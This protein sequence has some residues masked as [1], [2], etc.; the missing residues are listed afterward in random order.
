M[1]HSVSVGRGENHTSLGIGGYFRNGS[2]PAVGDRLNPQGGVTF[3]DR[4]A[5][6]SANGRSR[7]NPD[8]RTGLAG[9][10]V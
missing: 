6:R 1:N 7:P 3:P 10:R 9:V 2:I 4:H 5:A 8:I